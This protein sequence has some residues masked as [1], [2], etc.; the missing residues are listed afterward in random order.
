MGVHAF[1]LHLFCFW[2]FFV[3]VCEGFLSKDKH[4]TLPYKLS[5]LVSDFLFQVSLVI[6]NFR[7]FFSFFF[8]STHSPLLERTVPSDIIDVLTIT[9]CPQLFHFSA[10]LN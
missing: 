8:T 6:P 10:A 1:S 9:L 3:V 4:T 2:G 5:G 7:T